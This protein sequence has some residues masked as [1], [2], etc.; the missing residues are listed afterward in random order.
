MRDGGRLD[1]GW[2]TDEGWRNALLDADMREDLEKGLVSRV[3]LLMS[4]MELLELFVSKP[5]NSSRTSV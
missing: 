2:I 3:L 5:E 4:D 1:L